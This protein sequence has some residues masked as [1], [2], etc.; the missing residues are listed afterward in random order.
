MYAVGKVEWRRPV[1]QVDHLALGR[2]GVHAVGEQLAPHALDQVAVGVRPRA[3]LGLEQAPYP[4]DLALVLRVA[5]TAFLVAPV[6]GDA[7]LGM[8]VHLVGAD[9]HLDTL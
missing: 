7:Q 4:L 6:R 1:R 9:L 3:L 2:Q 5:R 8:L